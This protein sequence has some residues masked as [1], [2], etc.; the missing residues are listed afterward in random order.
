[1]GIKSNDKCP[2]ERKVE[3]ILKQT[4]SGQC[5]MKMQTETGEI[6]LQPKES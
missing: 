6:Q 4:L 5:N 1:V 2:Y 3:K